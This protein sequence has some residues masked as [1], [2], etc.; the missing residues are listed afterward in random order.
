MWC[1][2]LLILMCCS[3]ME[4]RIPADCFIVSYTDA[5]D[6]L[7]SY[8]Y[9]YGPDDRVVRKISIHLI[10]T[11]FYDDAGNVVLEKSKCGS[12]LAKFHL[13]YDSANTT[14]IYNTD[15]LL[16][17][18]YWEA[19]CLNCW[20]LQTYA[21][22]SNNQMI[23]ASVEFPGIFNLDSITR[24][25]SYPNANTRNYSSMILSSNVSPKDSYYHYY[26]YDSKANPKKRNAIDFPSIQTDNNIVKEYFGGLNNS[27][28]PPALSRQFTYQ[29]NA[30][31]YP[32][33]ITSDPYSGLAST[34][35]YSCKMKP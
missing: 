21:Y 33:T 7:M 18:S 30:D 27:L 12:E 10:T 17:T 4:F 28:T 34:Y 26:E 15:N 1:A 23:R 13:G 32:V 29:Y 19:N 20:H 24:E 22:N 16:I 31:G 5:H 9:E 2:W 25:Y 8:T 11:Y 14:H 3:K 6:S 35:E